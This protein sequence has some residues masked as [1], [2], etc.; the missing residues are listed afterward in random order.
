MGS[1]PHKVGEKVAAQRTERGL[2]LPYPIASCPR[3]NASCC[4]MSLCRRKTGNG[5]DALD[6]VYGCHLRHP[7]STTQLLPR[8][9]PSG[10]TVSDVLTGRELGG[11]QI[12]RPP[13]IRRAAVANRA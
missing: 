4:L 13:L 10:K 5:W 1:S 8:T 3:Q 7:L 6:N 11:P 12:L 2:A 9:A